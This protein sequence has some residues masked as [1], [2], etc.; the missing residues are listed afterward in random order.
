MILITLLPG[1]TQYR[2]RYS[3]SKGRT[4]KKKYGPRSW[5]ANQCVHRIHFHGVSSRTE[6]S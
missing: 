5:H 6:K 2:Y 3:S 4:T 1:G